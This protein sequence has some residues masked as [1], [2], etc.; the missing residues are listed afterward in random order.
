MVPSQLPTPPEYAG[1]WV[2]LHNGSIVAVSPDP[3]ALSQEIR[4]RAVPCVVYKVPA[5]AAAAPGPARD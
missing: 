2:G 1:L 4:D 3:G 5:A